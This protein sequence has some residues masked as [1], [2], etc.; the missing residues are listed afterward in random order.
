MHIEGNV[1]KSLIRHMFGEND[2]KAVR[3]ACEYM[4]V[5][6]TAWMQ[7]DDDRPPRAS[8]IMTH[9]ERKMFK[10]RISKMRMPTGYGALLRKAFASDTTKWPSGLKT[11]DYHR[12]LQD[13][14]PIAME[15]LASAEL[16]DAIMD[17]SRLLR[18]HI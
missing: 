12:L 13:I 11:H 10:A 8:W 5:H 15:G 3:D 14:L 17:L 16:R 9:R 7:D 18:Y 4:G 1:A 2:G 6:E